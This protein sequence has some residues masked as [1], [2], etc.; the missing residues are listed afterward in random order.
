MT[1]FYQVINFQHQ[2]VKTFKNLS[3]AEGHVTLLRAQ[4]PDEGFYIIE[5]FVVYSFGDIQ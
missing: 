3:D 2:P 4:Y 5:L 1:K